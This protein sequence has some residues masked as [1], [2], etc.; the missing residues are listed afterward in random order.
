[1]FKLDFIAYNVSCGGETHFFIVGIL[2]LNCYVANF[3]LWALA[4]GFNSSKNLSS[5]LIRFNV[6]IESV[7]S[8]TN[9][10]DVYLSDFY[11]LVK[12]Q[13]ILFQFFNIDFVWSTLH[14]NENTFFQDWK[15]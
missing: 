7:I 14:Q 2:H 5:R 8:L 6:G 9:G 11:A 1:M 15:C 10:P 12:L 3:V 13:D 4:D